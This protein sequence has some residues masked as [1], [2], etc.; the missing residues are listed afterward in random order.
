[1]ETSIDEQLGRL[2]NAKTPVGDLSR[3]SRTGQLSD[4][5]LA[6]SLIDKIKAPEILSVDS[7][8][9]NNGKLNAISALQF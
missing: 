4:S 2:L 9:F 6:Q 7:I 8:S 3:F 1:M 5:R